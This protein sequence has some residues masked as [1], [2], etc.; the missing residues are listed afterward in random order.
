MKPFY[1]NNCDKFQKDFSQTKENISQSVTNFKK[2]RYQLNCNPP[3]K[4]TTAEFVVIKSLWNDLGVNKEYQ[5][6]FKKYFNELETDEEKNDLLG[7]EKS[8]LRKFREVL[9]KLSEEISNR[10]NNIVKLKIYSSELEKFLNASCNYDENNNINEEDIFLNIFQ[11]IQKEIKSYRVNTVNVIN[12]IIKVR[13]V[14]SYY[15][16]NK[17]WDPSRV[18]R[19]YS[20][21]QNYLLTMLHDLQFI[22][23]SIILNYIKTSD[24]KHQTDLFFSNCKYLKPNDKTKLKLPITLELQNEINKCKYI[25]LQDSLLNNLKKEEKKNTLLERNVFS[26]K[27]FHAHNHIHSAGSNLSTMSKKSKNDIHLSGD[28][29]EKKYYEMFGHNKINLSRTL[30]YL[31]KTMGHKYENMFYNENDLYNTRKNMDIMNKFISFK[32]QEDQD[33]YESNNDNNNENNDI[34]MINYNTGIMEY[35]DKK[36]YNYYNNM[37]SNHMNYFNRIEQINKNNEDKKLEKNKN[38]LLEKKPS[39][40]NIKK[41]KKMKKKHKKEKPENTEKIENIENSKDKNII[42]NNETNIINQEKEKENE[43]N[44]KDSITKEKEKEKE[45]NLD[46]KDNIEKEKEIVIKKFDIENIQEENVINL[47]III[48]N[49]E[50]EEEKEKESNQNEENNDDKNSK[51]SNDNNIDDNNKEN[52]ENI[53]SKISKEK[54]IEEGEIETIKKESENEIE[55]YF[56]ISQ[57]HSKISEDKHISK[58][59]LLKYRPYTEEEIKRFN[60]EYDL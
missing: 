46:N 53:N 58:I 45:N 37:M 10:D 43:L 18:N 2:K 20:F 19:S 47:N 42:V 11:S 32:N 16:I 40:V 1:L 4:T 23:N 39:S 14:S 60:Q 27:S 9:I 35:G 30:Y 29:N 57:N 52:N 15:E 34:D 51:I 41:R 59:K 6:E 28:N 13:E 55:S 26:A 31:K 38:D 17:K 54:G 8:H 49:K 24:N 48:E 36:R 7:Y 12:K 50:K 5:N 25:I 56:T 22:N 44:N 3:I 33:D 21:N